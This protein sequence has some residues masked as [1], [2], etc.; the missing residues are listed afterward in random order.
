MR[1]V[2]TRAGPRN[3]VPPST[4]IRFGVV[5]EWAREGKIAGSAEIADAARESLKKLLRFMRKPP[6]C[7]A[8]QFTKEGLDT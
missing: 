2:S 6:I 1:A 8:S 3:T 7:T 4:K 5:L